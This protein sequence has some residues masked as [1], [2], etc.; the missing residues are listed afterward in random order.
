MQSVKLHKFNNYAP[1]APDQESTDN[2]KVIFQLYL[3]SGA[4]VFFFDLLFNQGMDQIRN[5]TP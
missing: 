2:F 3:K 4:G 5:V 1:S